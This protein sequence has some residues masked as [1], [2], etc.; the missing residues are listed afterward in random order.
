M[1]VRSSVIA[2]PC[3]ERDATQCHRALISEATTAGGAVQ[4]I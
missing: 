1:Q 2:L 4:H 3:F